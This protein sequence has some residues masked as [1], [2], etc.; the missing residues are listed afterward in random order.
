MKEFQKSKIKD[1]KSPKK[2]ALIV[3]YYCLK[4]IEEYFP[5]I[6]AYNTDNINLPEEITAHNV[7]NLIRHVP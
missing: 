1:Y 3:I 7:T 5:H 2:Q 6:G 4:N